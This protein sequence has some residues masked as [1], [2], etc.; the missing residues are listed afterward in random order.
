MNYH[1]IVKESMTNGDGLRAVLFV[2]GCTHACPGCQNPVTWNKDGGMKFDDEA[3]KELFAELEKSY[4]S[5][6]TFSGGDPLAIFNRDEVLDLIEEIK[7]KYPDKTIW[8]YTGYEMNEL[9]E[10]DPIFLS[11][12]LDNI[13]VLV[14]GPYIESLRSI[15]NPWAGSTNQTVRRSVNNWEPDNAPV[16]EFD[17]REGNIVDSKSC[18]ADLGDDYDLDN[19]NY[20]L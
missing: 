4:V 1:D 17:D 2:S 13:D 5:G 8:V 18:C 3:K 16:Y 14:D 10:Q 20:E 6:V 15:N 11:K 7:E 19:I 9:K 12:L